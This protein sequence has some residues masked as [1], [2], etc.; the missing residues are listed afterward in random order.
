MAIL[1]LNHAVLY[2]RDARRSSRFYE[3]VLGFVPVIDDAA[4]RYAFLRAPASVNHHDTARAFQHRAAVPASPA[5]RM[6]TVG[7]YH[8]GRRAF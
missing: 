5:G 4:G 8:G 6:A 7:I 1:G 3:E 2:V